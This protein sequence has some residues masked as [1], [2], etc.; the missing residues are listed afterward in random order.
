VIIAGR[1]DS[2]QRFSHSNTSYRVK[3]SRFQ[4]K[5]T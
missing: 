3:F 1:N 2:A 5:R 4:T